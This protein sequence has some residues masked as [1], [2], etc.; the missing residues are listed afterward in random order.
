MAFKEVKL[1]EGDQPASAGEFWSCKAIGDKFAGYF[2]DA[3]ES[4]GKFGKRVVYRFRDPKGKDWKMPNLA[5]LDKKLAAALADGM[6]QGNPA[7]IEYVKALP[8]EGDKTMAII[9]VKWDP[10]T[11]KMPAAAAATPPA[12]KDDADFL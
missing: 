9:S 12:P 6:K 11:V 2:L 8:L 4:D 3:K 5:N 10:D 1:A 7:V